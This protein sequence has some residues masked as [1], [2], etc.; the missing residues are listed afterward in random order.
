MN[1][2]DFS[3]GP[4]LGTLT[5]TL[6][7]VKIKNALSL[8]WRDAAPGI[9]LVENQ[10][11]Y[12]DRDASAEV[13]FLKGHSIFVSE[14]SLIRLTSK[15]DE[16]ALD[17]SKGFITASLSK[18]NPLKVKLNGEEYTLTGDAANVQINLQDKKGEIGV[19]SGEVKVT[20]Q[21]ENYEIDPKTALTIEDDVL[22]K[23]SVQF[24]AQS[25]K[26]IIFSGGPEAPVTFNWLPAIEANI[27]I[28]HRRDFD[29]VVKINGSGSAMASLRPGQYYYKI[30]NPTGQSIIGTFRIIQETPPAVLRPK[31]NEELF[32]IG[33]SNEVFLEW[34]AVE[35]MNYLIEIN[36][37]DLR[38]EEIRGGFL[39]TQIK[40]TS[41]SYRI[42]INSPE[43]PE[44]V[45]TPWQN[46][47]ATKVPVAKIP[48]NLSPDEVEFQ[49]YTGE[50][51][52]VELS[53]EGQEI[54]DLEI[55][56]PDGKLETIPK[57]KNKF[58]YE[59]KVPGKYKWRLRGNEKAISFSEWSDT[60]TFSL[61][62]L[63]KEVSKE[64]IQ[65]IQLERPDQ[66]VTFNWN[67]ES[68]TTTIFELSRDRDFKTIILRDELKED[69]L[70]VVM[71]ET[72]I[73]YWRSRQFKS[74]GTI[75]VSEPKR[76]II[77]PVPAPEKPEK[78]PDMEVPL[79][80]I[81]ETSFID[82]LIPSAHADELKGVV[83]LELPIT[84]DAKSF[85]VKIYRDE[86]LSDLVLEKEVSSKNL[87]WK[88]ALPGIYY[89]QYAI[90]DHWNRKSEFSDPSKLVVRDEISNNP[91]K[92]KL[93]SPIRAVGVDSKELKFKWSGS[94]R[95]VEYNFEISDADDFKK[96]ILSKKTNKNEFSE[97]GV[98]LDPKLHFWRVQS[99]GR[100][101]KSVMS[102]TGRFTI[103][104]PI[105]K[106]II[107]DIP[108]PP[109]AK[110]ELKTQAYLGW[111]PSFDTYEF[112]DNADGEIQGTT[113]MGAFAKG[114]HRKNSF[115][116]TG[117]LLHQRGKVFKSQ[118]YLF[119]RLS[120]DSVKLLK[121]FE[122]F[123]WG[124]G[125]SIGHT[126]GYA[127]TTNFDDKVSSQSV[128]GLN[129]GFIYRN[130]YSLSEL[131]DIQGK[132]Q[133]LLGEIKQLD[134]EADFI[135]HYK[136]YLLL[137]GVGLASRDYDLSKGQQSSM[138]F[139]VGLGKDF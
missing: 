139:S 75:E 127:Y 88:D 46:V 27:L 71:P 55:R 78:L 110:K 101:G 74:D 3:S 123:K 48:V 70:K 62:D 138:K 134:I 107:Q 58:I 21:S 24:I 81:P 100:N 129:Y 94:P 90:V 104:P 28:S 135:H 73:F 37:G 105:E 98:E 102:N 51:E 126:S 61:E 47:S 121:D 68:G 57:I 31:D 41:F 63:S 89:W 7:V 133:Y 111:T 6:S 30:Q 40:G 2:E 92:P 13:T 25:M 131:W 49:S 113:F 93:I 42:R 8:D 59:A 22:K 1:S 54:A 26:K 120:F 118:N 17:V 43:R 19:L 124:L 18:N 115:V 69:N 12:T 65:R 72:G 108:L 114:I 91:E 60:K 85:I 32:L 116:I 103:L 76:V 112:S 29:E 15:N 125:L 23:V 20:S 87:E 95:N 80:E 34:N 97:P 50:P 5:R 77:E 130:Y 119:Q 106:T 84:K 38:T 136:N 11:I 39:K 137:F 109:V 132:A 82:F 122:K 64:G 53:W 128:S 99:T 83:N 66:Q 96:K 44:A 117:E 16:D 52:K 36:D 14:N 4:K 10:L 86:N 79:E 33:D 56:S 67:R 35:G 9:D 45:F